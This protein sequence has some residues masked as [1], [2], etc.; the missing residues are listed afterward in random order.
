M[1]GNIPFT[2]KQVAK[3][4][5]GF[6]PSGNYPNRKQRRSHL[7]KSNNN[8]HHGFHVHHYQLVDG[9]RIAHLSVYASKGNW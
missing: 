6:T 2:Q 8:S 1:K 5:A 9:K 3:L 4:R 7:Q